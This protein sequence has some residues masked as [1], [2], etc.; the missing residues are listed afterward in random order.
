VRKSQTLDFGVLDPCLVDLYR[1]RRQTCWGSPSMQPSGP[2]AETVVLPSPGNHG[3]WI[4]E[5]I[6]KWPALIQVSEILW[7]LPRYHDF[8]GWFWK[9]LFLDLMTFLHWTWTLLLDL[10]TSLLEIDGFNL[11][12]FW[13]VYGIGWA[14]WF[15]T[16]LVTVNS[17]KSKEVK[18]LREK[19]LNQPPTIRNAIVHRVLHL[20][21]VS[22]HI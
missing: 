5:I 6:P 17:G 22:E 4:R 20:C 16:L 8:F 19:T 21:L 10:T 14:P 11:D 1:G 2:R 18:S 13:M 15:T 7:P 9:T 12:F 3:E